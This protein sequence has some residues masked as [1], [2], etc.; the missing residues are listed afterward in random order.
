MYKDYNLYYTEEERIEIELDMKLA[1]EEEYKHYQALHSYKRKVLKRLSR[2]LSPSYYKE[3]AYLVED[4]TLSELSIV[5]ELPS[6][7][8]KRF[9][10]TSRIKYYFEDEVYHDSWSDSFSGVSYIPIKN[11]NYLK[12]SY[13]G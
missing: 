9:D 5:K 13:Y 1:R 12:V 8:E 6:S 2:R 3:V 10:I 4:E 11:G 7:C